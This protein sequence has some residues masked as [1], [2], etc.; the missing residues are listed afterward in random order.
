VVKLKGG[1]WRIGTEIRTK[2]V[3]R[4]KSGIS[5]PEWGGKPG[6]RTCR[7][8]IR[9]A[10]YVVYVEADGGDRRDRDRDIVA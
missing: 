4:T 7:W 6:P 5:D 1:R 10:L 8:G 3:G 2:K 9:L